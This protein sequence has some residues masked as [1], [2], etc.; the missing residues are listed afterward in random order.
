M[1]DLAVD[2]LNYARRME[3]AGFTRQQAEAMAEEQA[4]LIDERLATKADVQEVRLAIEAGRKDIEVLRKETTQQIEAL[5]QETRLSI[6]ILRRDLTIRLGGI[7]MGSV[8]AP[9]AILA[10]VSRLVPPHP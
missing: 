5:R 3:Q 6:E 10:L 4:R 9:T 8:A 7:V 2:T 1:A